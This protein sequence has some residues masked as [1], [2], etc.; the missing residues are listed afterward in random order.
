MKS[1][2]LAALL[3]GAGV[4]L[5]PAVS[6]LADPAP[7]VSAS[8]ATS[9]TRSTQNDSGGAMTNSHALSPAGTGGS[10]GVAI[11]TRGAG[12]GANIRQPASQAANTSLAPTTPPS[13]TGAPP[14]PA[15]IAP[16]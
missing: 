5:M 1:R 3:L 12:T 7:G 15:S 13:P 6:C 16:R 9:T 14:P 2:T 10:N 11:G 8:G 4:G